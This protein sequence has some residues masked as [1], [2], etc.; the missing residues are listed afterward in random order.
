MRSAKVCVIQYLIV[1]TIFCKR[2]V[3]IVITVCIPVVGELLRAKNQNAFVSGLVVFD[4]SQCR[5]SLT[6]TN[7]IS[8]NTTIVFFEFIDNGKSSVTLEVEQHIPHLAVFK[9]GCLVWEC[10]LGNIIQKLAE[11]IIEGHEVDEFGSVLVID[12]RN[13]FNHLVSYILEVLLVVPEL[14]KKVNIALAHGERQSL[15]EVVSI[16]ATLTTEINR[17]ELIKGHISVLVFL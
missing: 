17:C 1:Q 11:N 12:R 4:N 2:V 8:Q 7:R 16:V 5:K 3:D 14:L 9:A 10:V 6:E 13:V 15:R